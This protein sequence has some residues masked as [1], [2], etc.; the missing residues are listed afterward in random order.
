MADPAAGHPGPVGWGDPR[1]LVGR[2]RELATLNAACKEGGGALVVRGPAGIGKTRLVEAALAEAELRGARVL[3]ARFGDL[4]RNLPYLGLRLALMPI[5]EVGAAT[6][7]PDEED[8]EPLRSALEL[9]VTDTGDDASRSRLA[10]A[11]ELGCR[12]LARWAEQSRVVVALDDL[13]AADADTLR[14]LSLLVAH[15]RSAGVVFL[16]TVRTGTPPLDVEVAAVIERLAAEGLARCLDLEELDEADTRALVH[17]L[18][19]AAPDDELVAAVRGACGGNPFFISEAVSALRASGAIRVE[20]GWAGLVDTA[21]PPVLTARATLLHR[22]LVLDPP[23]RRLVRVLSAFE[24]V[25]LSDLALVARLAELTEAEADRAFD[26]LVASG[27]IEPRG[28]GFAFTHPIVRTTLY[29]D[30][31]PAERRRLHRLIAEELTARRAGGTP[32]SVAEI[33]AHL[34]A[35]AEPGDLRAAS[36]LAQAAGEIVASAPLTAARWYARARALVT[37]RPPPTAEDPLHPACLQAAECRALNLASRPSE[38]ARV[39]AAALEVLPAGRLRTRTAAVVA[40]SLATVGRFEDALAVTDGLSEAE[41]SGPRIRASRAHVLILLDRFADA[42][43]EL[44]AGL[45]DA[46]DATSLAMVLG[47]L[48]SERYASG[49]LA[50]C[51][52]HLDRQAEL[53]ARL[54]PMARVSALALRAFYLAMAGLPRRATESLEAARAEADRRGGPVSSP[55][56]EVAT[57]LRDWHVGDW[58]AVVDW[59]RR[60][61]VAP[62]RSGVYGVLVRIAELVVATDRG[63]FTRARELAEEVGSGRLGSTYATWAIARCEH[64]RGELDRARRLLEEALDHDR[65]VSRRSSLHLLL[66]ALVEVELESGRDDAA[67]RYADELARFARTATPW[68]QAVAARCSA[69]VTG[70]VDLAAEAVR[71]ADRE[72]L[73]VEAARSRVALAELGGDPVTNLEAAHGVLD[74]LGAEPEVRRVVALMRDRGISPPRA[75]GEPDGPLTDTERQIA[76]LVYEGLTNRQ[77]ARALYLSPKTIEVYLSRVFAKTGCV[78]RLELAVAVSEGRLPGVPAG[79]P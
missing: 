40:Q 13:H 71:L 19:G 22:I 3:R 75:P 56:F 33:A 48:A 53:D 4:D 15:L 77:I 25:Q 66:S 18:L 11:F 46:E 39:G 62:E 45:A 76:R 5:L 21:T 69:R 79:D 7:A 9:R 47:A 34:A 26:T 12:L 49:D 54:G 78:N 35:A 70:D 29:D 8:L 63:R 1:P 58:D 16:A 55:V 64:V 10:A 41:R 6:D 31:G 24:R 30:V 38:A 14:A 23:A 20:G 65:A 74:R 51:L 60:V 28:D 72:G 67:R 59:S 61:G 52:A 27:L 37:D 43:A 50:G 73:V 42:R 68:V 32:V 57:A 36:V 44:D 17:S 2:H